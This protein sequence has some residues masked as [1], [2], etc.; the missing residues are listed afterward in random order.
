MKASKLITK[1]QANKLYGDY[2]KFGF[3][4]KFTFEQFLIFTIKL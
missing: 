4:Q 3:N 2:I 1:E